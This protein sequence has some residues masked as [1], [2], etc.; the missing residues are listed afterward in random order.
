METIDS[1]LLGMCD[2]TNSVESVEVVSS[3]SLEIIVFPKVELEISD[4]SCVK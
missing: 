1:G 2:D 4:C 3:V